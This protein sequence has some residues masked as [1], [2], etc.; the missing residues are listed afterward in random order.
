MRA[1]QKIQGIATDVAAGSGIASLEVGVPAGHVPPIDTAEVSA[2]VSAI[3][4]EARD[5]DLW[6]FR[7]DADGTV[8]HVCNPGQPLEEP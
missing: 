7:D 5:G 2:P 6:I 3:V 8:A 4:A 1:N